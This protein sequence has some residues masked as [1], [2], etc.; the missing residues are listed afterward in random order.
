MA[1]IEC[2]GLAPTAGSRTELVKPADSQI[3][4]GYAVVVIPV[5]ISTVNSFH[6]HKNICIY[7]HGLVMIVI[8]YMH[9]FTHRYSL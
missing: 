6:Q 5:S 3:G 1:W 2:F 7:V 8:V 4:P 9:E